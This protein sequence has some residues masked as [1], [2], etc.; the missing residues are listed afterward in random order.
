MAKKPETEEKA[1][2][3]TPNKEQSERFIHTARELGVD[4]SGVEFERLAKKI[5]APSARCKSG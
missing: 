4:E 5:I 1:R 2:K 3:K